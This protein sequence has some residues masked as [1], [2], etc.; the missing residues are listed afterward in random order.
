V[1][2]VA[3]SVHH[4]PVTLAEAR[5]AR[6]RI[7]GYAVRTPLVRLQAPGPPEIYLKLENLQPIG[8]FKIRGAANLI[9]QEDRAALKKGV[10]TASAGN[11]GQGV[12]WCAH[13]LGIPC[14]VLVPEDGSLN[15]IARMERL[16]ARVE[17]VTRPEFYEAFSRRAHPGMD[18]LF[19]HAFS[20]ERMMAGNATIALEILEDLPEV[21]TVVA[22]Y[23]GGGLSCGIASVLKEARPGARVF[24]VEPETSAPLRAA[25]DAGGIVGIES[26]HTFIDGAG[27]ARLYPEMYELAVKV[28]AGAVA[29]PVAAV[30]DAIR[31]LAESTRVVVEGAGALSVAAALSGRVPGERVCCVVSGGNIDTPLLAGIL[32]G[33]FE[34]SAAQP[35]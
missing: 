24:A 1:G 2:A 9:L 27:A 12:A 16:G 17:R 13:E 29:V 28:L 33:T 5:A 3:G 14:T 7:R 23:G 30:V 6:E 32:Q 25:F 19:V 26:V 15:K 22:A 10:W 20:D 21:D 34:P 35:S 4:R 31:L 8:A 11:M 18:G